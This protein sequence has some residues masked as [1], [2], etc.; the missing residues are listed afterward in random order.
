MRR[1][2]W[3]VWSE[4]GPLRYERLTWPEVAR[5]A[6]E[7]R[8]ALIPVATLEDHGLHLPV[9]TDLRIV[10][11]ICERAAARA[12]DRVVLLPAIPTATTPTT[13]TSRA[14]SP[15]AG[16]PSSATAPTSAAP[17]PATAS[18]GWCSSTATAPTRTWSRRRRDWSWWTGPR[19]WPRPPSTWQARR[20][21]RSSSGC[22]S[23]PAAGW[24]TPASWRPRS[25]WPSTPRRW[26]WSWRWTSAPIRGRARL[27][28]LVGRAAEADAVVV[29]VQPLRGPGRRHPRH[30]LQRCGPAGGGGHRVPGLGG[31]AAGQAPARA[32]PAG[33]RR[34]DRAQPRHRA[35][36][37]NPRADSEASTCWRAATVWLRS[38]PPSCS[39][40]TSPEWT[41]LSTRPAITPAP[42][43]RQS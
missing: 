11:E 20:P 30:R 41:R 19:C 10:S 6:G 24:P 3:P 32:A 5:A 12:A 4:T 15:S 8:V 42:G 2:T 17:W 29:V 9:D 23:R 40:T 13:W 1:W 37:R 34:R 27:A 33:R 22:A 36:N 7:D 43:R 21:S 18:G 39:R 16:T 26:P 38:P 28:G 14:R 31:G 35:L 25:T